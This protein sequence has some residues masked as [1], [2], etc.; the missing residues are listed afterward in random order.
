MSDLNT[1]DEIVPEVSATPQ[2]IR[3]RSIMPTIGTNPAATASAPEV[4]S[5]NWIDAISDFA[6]LAPIMSNLFTGSPESV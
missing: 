2:D 6:T 5:P 1:I 4:S 3:T